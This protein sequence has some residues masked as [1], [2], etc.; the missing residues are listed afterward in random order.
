MCR[1]AASVLLLIFATRAITAQD[2][3]LDVV[4]ARLHQYLGDYAE[5]LPATVAVERYQQRVGT[6][7]RVLLESEF[8]IVRVPNHPQWLGFRDVMK[9][10]GKA[11]RVTTDVWARCLKNRECD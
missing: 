9:V 3:T 6:I 8:G 11:W 2:V 5:L 7:E 10:N 1:R 4:L